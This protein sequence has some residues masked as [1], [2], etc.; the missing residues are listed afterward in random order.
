VLGCLPF[1]TSAGVLVDDDGGVCVFFFSDFLI[2]AMGADK[3]CYFGCV[4]YF[5]SLGSSTVCM[6]VLICAPSLPKSN[7]RKQK[8]RNE[9]FW[10]F[11]RFTKLYPKFHLMLEFLTN[12]IIIWFSL[13]CLNFSLFLRAGLNF[14]L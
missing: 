13:L 6:T 3:L 10:F 8:N 9:F 2:V 5:M 7:S 12:T 14:S 11:G 1:K 4:T